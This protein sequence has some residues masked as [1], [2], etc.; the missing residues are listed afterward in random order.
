[1][2]TL[3]FAGSLSIWAGLIVALTAGAFCYWLYRQE[4]LRTGCPWGRTL[5][6][7]RAIAVVLIVLMLTGPTL[8]H[9]YREGNPGQLTILID[10]SQS[11]TLTDGEST[12]RFDRATRGLTNADQQVLKQLADSHEINVVRGSQSV[13]N[14]LWE[15]TLLQSAELPENLDAWR[16]ARFESST[17]LG[18]LLVK[19][20]SSALVLITDGQMNGGPSLEQVARQ[21]LSVNKPIFTI[22]MGRNASP[23]DVTIID[24][25]Y[26]DRLYR[27]DSL[28]GSFIVRETLPQGT[29]Y[30]LRIM[31]GETVVWNESLTSLG[32]GQRSIAFKFPINSIVKRF[33]EGSQEKA[34][35]EATVAIRLQGEVLLGS[36]DNSQDKRREIQF[37]ASM[38]RAKV[39]IVDGRSRWETRYLK[40]LFERDSFWELTT[41]IADPEAVAEGRSI[42][43]RGVSRDRFPNSEESLLEFDLIILGEIPAEAL[44]PE[45]QTWVQRFV[46]ESGGGL[47]VIDGRRNH[48]SEDSNA[49]LSELLPV[50]RNSLARN[51]GA[52]TK[53]IRIDHFIPTASGNRLAAFQLGA[54]AASNNSEDSTNPVATQAT[55]SELL[56]QRAGIWD[57]LPKVALTAG[58][59]PLPGSEV[60]A[61]L[62]TSS[63]SNSQNSTPVLVTRLTGSGRVL[64][65]A[66]D[67]TW[68]W[69]YKV[70][71]EFHQR[72]WNQISRWVMR[73]P[74]T[75]QNDYISLDAGK[76][77]YRQGQDIEIRCRLRDADGGPLISSNVEAILSRPDHADTVLTLDTDP[78]LPGVYRG[79]ATALADGEYLVRVSAVGLPKE[80]MQLSTQFVVQ[81]SESIEMQET[82]IN[83]NVLRKVAEISGGRYILENQMDTLVDVLKPLSQGRI[84][85]NELS[86]WQSYWWFLPIV[87][88]LSVEWWLRKKA[89]LL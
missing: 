45:E 49:K 15:S 18:N 53:E 75:V 43:K 72:F 69:R 28:S 55:Q 47:I 3:Q 11:M 7:L 66:T 46:S 44:T 51:D 25:K 83:S 24:I 42:L 34:E 77:N 1:M 54:S 14:S 50:S 10:D 79:L 67:E 2:T 17:S 70:G 32:V 19:E 58:V 20:N 8:Q 76:M 68:R 29:P 64:Y 40:N 87:S 4:T 80:A 74:Y 37:W 48:W 71:D 59:Q 16:P 6:L 78:V 12:D 62:G 39:L 31:D 60:L 61:T 30:S 52:I 22:G 86:L 33:T 36:G 41:V 65:T 85:Q 26:P 5:P 35:S 56:V 23:E 27:K 57:S 63:E 9:R 73:T 13:T 21:Y 84:V 88:V 38:N 82:S 89:G 81:A